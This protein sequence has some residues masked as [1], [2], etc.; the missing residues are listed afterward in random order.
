[1]VRLIA[2]TFLCVWSTLGMA[3]TADHPLLS[4]PQGATVVAHQQITHER[5]ELPVGLPESQLTLEFP[6]KTVTG[7]LTRHAYQVRGTSSLA[8]FQTYRSQLT[9]AGFEILFSCERDDCGDLRQV[10]ALG[11]AIA[12]G[13]NLLGSWRQPY[14][15]AAKHATDSGTIHVGLFTG[16]KDGESVVH[17]VIIDPAQESLELIQVDTSY[18]KEPRSIEAAEAEISES[19][20]ARDH[21]LMSRYPGSRIRE[22]RHR[23]YETFS[24]P[25]SAESGLSTGLNFERLDLA[26]EITQ[27]FYELGG[28]SSLQ[29]YENYRAALD[30]ADFEIMF[31]CK[32]G[33]CG[34][35]TQARA[36]GAQISAANNVYNYYRK[37]YYLV[38]KRRTLSGPAYVGIFVGAYRDTTAV[39]QVVIETREAEVD[40]VAVNPD[41]LLQE[42]EEAGRASIYG[43]YFDSNQATVKDE[44]KPALDSVGQL[45]DEQSSLE[46]YVVGHTDDTGPVE[47]NLKLSKE[48]AEA[49][50]QRL[51]KD[52]GIDAKRLHAAGVGAYAPTANNATKEGREQNRRVELVKRLVQ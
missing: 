42:L 30:A 34:N 13:E 1:M 51:V 44:S 26:G 43:I 11:S 31:E 40:L 4:R 21:P 12:I 46:L 14:Y 8:L 18:L 45:L 41:L 19:E 47:H 33:E 2:L 15:L 6:V 49:V 16:G 50:V 17:Q 48:R 3:R 32:L 28:I 9:G 36:L 39:Q 29:V 27:H 35:S 25:I 37:P 52:Y 5:F 23:D 22:R 20:R 10:R 38:G 7:N 24:L